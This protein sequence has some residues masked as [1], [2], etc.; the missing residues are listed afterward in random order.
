MDYFSD[1]NPVIYKDY[2]SFIDTID[3]KKY[4]Q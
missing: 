3:E 1:I 4:M 2:K